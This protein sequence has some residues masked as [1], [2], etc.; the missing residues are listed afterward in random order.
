[1][2]PAT[3][4]GTGA[5]LGFPDV[6]LTP[7]GPVV[8]PVPYPNIGMHG[9]AIAFSPN[10]MLSGMNAI[11]AIASI[12]LTMGDEAGVANPFIK[13]MGRFMM[14]NP[15][16]SVNMMPGVCLCC[17]TSGNNSNDALGLVCVPSATNVFYTY[18][19]PG[20]PPPSTEGAPGDG[21]PFARRL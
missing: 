9:M 14:G 5:N 13:Q 20:A 4:R 10:V 21:D 3:N 2:L 1:M 19:A 15:V 12:P 8:A 18:A 16:V 7:M 11:S 6:C 17:P